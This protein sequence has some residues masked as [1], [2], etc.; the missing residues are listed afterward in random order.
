MTAID[1]YNNHPSRQ[2]LHDSIES[3]KT[4]KVKV[5][6]ILKDSLIQQYLFDDYLSNYKLTAD[7]YQ[8]FLDHFDE[9]KD[10]AVKSILGIKG[11]KR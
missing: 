6:I 10:K 4:H 2:Y 11:S 3:A 9:V 7:P 1:Y 5:D 8:Y